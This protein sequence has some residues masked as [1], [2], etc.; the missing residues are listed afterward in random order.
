MSEL[1]TGS[2]QIPQQLPHSIEAEQAV[3]GALMLANEAFDSVASLITEDDFY[4]QDHR[5]IFE[6]MKGLAD[7]DQPLDPITLSEA[8]KSLNLLGAA[9]G[10]SYLVKIFAP[11][12]RLFLSALLSEN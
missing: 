11:T 6:T 9:G 12:L 1:V 10:D 8:L 2:A 5:L 7:K 3:L 4:G